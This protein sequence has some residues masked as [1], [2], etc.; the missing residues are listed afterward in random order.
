MTNS[1]YTAIALL[2]DRSGSMQS[3]RTDAEGGIRTFIEDQRKE[4]GKCTLRVSQ[5]DTVYE[6]VYA[7]T[8]IQQAQFPVIIPRGMTALMDA[9]GSLIV[10]FGEEL[11]ALPEADRPGKVV[12]VVVTDGYENASMEWSEKKIKEMVTEQQNSFGWTFLFLAADQDA[13]FEGAKYGV[14]KGHTLSTGISGQSVGGTY[15]AMSA[16]VRR[17]RGGDSAEFTSEERDKAK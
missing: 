12:F 4:P 6:T 13:A 1:D 15:S 9:W 14:L 7:S 11:A 10:E 16:S 5:F 2:L 3:I 8:D 17:V